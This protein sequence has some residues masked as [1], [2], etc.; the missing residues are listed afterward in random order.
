MSEEELLPALG[1]HAADL[2]AKAAEKEDLN[3]LSDQLASIAD[4]YELQEKQLV[5]LLP[6]SSRVDQGGW[7]AQECQPKPLRMITSLPMLMRRVA[8]SN[9]VRWMIST[10]SVSPPP[11]GPPDL[12]SRLQRT[13]AWPTGFFAQHLRLEPTAAVAHSSCTSGA[14]SYWDNI[15]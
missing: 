12:E 1:N 13:T 15:P 10:S 5:C 6:V 11:P 3:G 9:G 2:A 7:P 4:W 14:C 8:L